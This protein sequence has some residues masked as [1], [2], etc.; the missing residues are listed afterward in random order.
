MDTLHRV[1]RADIEFR[2]DL[3][4]LIHLQRSARRDNRIGA[5]IGEHLELPRRGLRRGRHHALAGLAGTAAA[6]P[7]PPSSSSI[8]GATSSA[9]A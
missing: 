4:N 3:A 9:K 8:S 2:D 6:K 7:A 1:G 5:L